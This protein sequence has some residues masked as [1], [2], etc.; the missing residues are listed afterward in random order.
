METKGKWLDEYCN[1]CG[2]QINTW[3]KKE[4]PT[5][6]GMPQNET[7]A[8]LLALSANSHYIESPFSS[9]CAPSRE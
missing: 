3:E 4:E 9:F 8:F 7:R 6:E 2:R 1:S 5:E